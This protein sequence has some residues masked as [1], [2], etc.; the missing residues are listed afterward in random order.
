MAKIYSGE[1][2]GAYCERLTN[3]RKEGKTLFMDLAEGALFVRG[4]DKNKTVC[5]KFGNHGGVTV[6]GGLFIQCAGETIIEKV[7]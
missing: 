2:F 6:E 5:R 7:S 3:L 4:W 1:T